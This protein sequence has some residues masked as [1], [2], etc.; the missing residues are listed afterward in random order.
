MRCERNGR[1]KNDSQD[2]SGCKE[3]PRSFPETGKN[4]EGVGGRGWRAQG[5]IRSLVLNMLSLRCA[6]DTQVEL[7]SK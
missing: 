7:A 6:S 4:A 3:E 1:V 5:K 2:L